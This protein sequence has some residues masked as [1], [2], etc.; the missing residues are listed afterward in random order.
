MDAICPTTKLTHLACLIPVMPN[1]RLATLRPRALVCRRASGLWARHIF[2][3]ALCAE[4]ALCV[5]TVGI[6]AQH[7]SLT[8]WIP[9]IRQARQSIELAHMRPRTM[10]VFKSTTPAK[11]ALHVAAVCIAT[12]LACITSRVPVVW[13]RGF[14]VKGTNP[15]LCFVPNGSLRTSDPC[16]RI[17]ATETALRM[18]TIR[19]ATEL[20][21]LALG[22]PIVRKVGFVREAAAA[23]WALNRGEVPSAAEATLHVL[24]IGIATQIAL[25]TGRIPEVANIDG[26]VVEVALA[27]RLWQ[28]R[29]G[30]GVKLASAA[31]DAPRA[32]DTSKLEA[33]PSPLAGQRGRAPRPR[34]VRGVVL[35]HQAV[36]SGTCHFAIWCRRI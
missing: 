24:A 13:S 16:E 36:V 31:S 2:E 3:G 12:V 26:L 27:P 7:A 33:L 5:H 4:S 18:D 28:W 23:C 9:E 6:A 21:D 10:N 15:A 35:T 30:C 32:A 14:V 29:R 17:V 34:G 20:A 11:A 22:I 25:P 19:P 8:L 1:Q